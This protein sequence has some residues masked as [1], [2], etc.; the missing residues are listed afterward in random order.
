MEKVPVSR[1]LIANNASW[2][3][4]PEEICMVDLLVIIGVTAGAFLG[5]NLDNLLLLV[6]MYSRYEHQAA[7]ATAGY[8]TGIIR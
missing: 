3:R 8:F 7:M 1:T 6:A 5:T 2:V 4:Q